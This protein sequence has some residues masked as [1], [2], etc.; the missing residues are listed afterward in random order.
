MLKEIKHPLFKLGMWFVLAAVG[1]VVSFVFGKL[2]QTGVI[3][4]PQ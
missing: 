3:K 1:I 2:V 4:W